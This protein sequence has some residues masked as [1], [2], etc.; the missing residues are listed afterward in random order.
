MS[1]LAFSIL[2]PFALSM[3]MTFSTRNSYLVRKI[4]GCVVPGSLHVG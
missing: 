2:Y 4:K 3:D 1:G